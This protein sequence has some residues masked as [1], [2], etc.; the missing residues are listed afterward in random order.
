MAR[1]RLTV[2]YDGAAYSGSQSQ[3]DGSG[4]QDAIEAALRRLTS[5]AIRVAI[6]G[7]TDRGVHAVGQVVAF[8]YG[9]RLSSSD[10]E[11]GLNALLPADISVREARECEPGFDPRR[12]ATSRTYEYRI[13]NRPQRSALA[14]GKATH[15]PAR[16][17]LASMS[18]A[19]RDLIGVHDFAPL[20]SDGP[21]PTIREVRD[22]ACWREG[23]MVY[24]RISA[25][26]FAKRMV[27][28][29]V[30]AL[31]NV[32]MGRWGPESVGAI[33]RGDPG[34]PVAPSAPAH[35]LYLLNVEYEAF[36]PALAAALAAATGD[37]NDL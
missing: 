1:I 6:A 3:P 33:L 11:R 14:N 22:C 23:D 29:I 18:L 34:A 10:F 31:L 15:V 12:A 5:Q 37:E 26:A 25:N 17:D 24:V 2:E 28:R 19:C 27:R 9:G 32:G 20:A 30:G 35:G 8:D 36:G 16:L 7:R 21:G 13:L 4:V